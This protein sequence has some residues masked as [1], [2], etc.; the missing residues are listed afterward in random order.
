MAKLR[1]SPADWVGEQPYAH[2]SRTP[3]PPGDH[4]PQR[5]GQSVSGWRHLLLSQP[6]SE[7]ATVTSCHALGRSGALGSMPWGPGTRPAGQ[8]S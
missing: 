4:Q 8:P 6:Q 1:R 3:I 5:R 2:I 7:A